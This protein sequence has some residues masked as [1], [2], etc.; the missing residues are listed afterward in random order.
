MNQDRSEGIRRYHLCLSLSW[1]HQLWYH[2]SN[3][4][5]WLLHAF[6]EPREKN[7]MQVFA[8]VAL[9]CK[10]SAECCCWLH[11]PGAGQCLGLPNSACPHWSSIQA[12]IISQVH[13]LSIMYWLPIVSS[14]GSDGM[15]LMLQQSWW[16]HSLIGLVPPRLMKYLAENVN[17]IALCYLRIYCSFTTDLA[18]KFNNWQAAAS[19][20]PMGLCWMLLCWAYVG[21]V[22]F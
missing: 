11:L 6:D 8:T 21:Y 17:S 13:Y 19:V 14:P 1:V 7:G 4:L 20:E 18:G 9:K 2:I 5:S 12:A 22:G 16:Y 3:Y 10:S 15:A